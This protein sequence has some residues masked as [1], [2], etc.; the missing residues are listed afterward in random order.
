MAYER[1]VRC[2]IGWTSIAELVLHTSRV[3]LATEL[4]V[5]TKLGIS[6][7]LCLYAALSAVTYVAMAS[8]SHALAKPS[9]AVMSGVAVVFCKAYALGDWAPRFEPR[10]AGLYVDTC[11]LRESASTWMKMIDVQALGRS[12]EY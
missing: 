12:S 3:T 6:S 8:S 7:L 1:M 10:G 9:P 5:S 11:A 2:F 4:P